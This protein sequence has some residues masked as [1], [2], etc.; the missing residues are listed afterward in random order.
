MSV[1]QP[2][3]QRSWILTG[4]WLRRALRPGKLPWR[5]R[6]ALPITSAVLLLLVLLP[7]VLLQRL[8]RPRAVG[9][10]QLL[11]NV[12]LLQSF[13]PT[14]GRPVPLLWR[15]RLG[16]PLASALWQQQRGP[17]WQLWGDHTDAPPLLAFSRSTL[18][19][20]GKAILPANG[21]AVGDLVVVAAE[22]LSRQLL[23]SCTAAAAPPPALA[24]C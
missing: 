20:A 4:P 24:F 16:T 1:D 15:Q 23:Q 5:N 8:P 14:P 22:P 17:W 13:P 2:E 21:L 6:P 9:L 10:E 7:A 18:P 3:T 12:S 19:G 11:T